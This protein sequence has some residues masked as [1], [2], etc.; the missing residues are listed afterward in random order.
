A[1]GAALWFGMPLNSIGPSLERGV[2]DMLGGLTAV[3]CFGAMFGRVIADSGAARRIAKTLIGAV[4]VRFILIAMALTGLIVGIPL[5]YT[6]GFVVL[7][8][9]VFSLGARTQLP[10]VHLGIPLLCG[11]SI[12]HGFLPPHPSPIALVRLFGAD[13][14]LTLIYGVIV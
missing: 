10:A 7:V 1:L 4:G 13:M 9:L 12:A 14:G 6:V 2:G 8:P 3:I 11:L 5:F